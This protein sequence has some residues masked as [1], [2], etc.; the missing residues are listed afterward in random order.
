MAWAHGFGW[1]MQHG[2]STWVWVGAYSMAEKTRAST[3]PVLP[4]YTATR[5]GPYS[6]GVQAWCPA[7]PRYCRAL[8]PACCRGVLPCSATL[9]S[10]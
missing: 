5:V 4:R 3:S 10:S 9:L 8:L 1:G 2:L 6:A 7:L